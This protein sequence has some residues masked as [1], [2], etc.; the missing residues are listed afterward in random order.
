MRDGGPVMSFVAP[1]TSCLPLKPR[2]RMLPRN[3]LSG[4]VSYRPLCRR[5]PE[6][7]PRNNAMN[8]ATAGGVMCRAAKSSIR[9]SW[10]FAV[11]LL[12][13]EL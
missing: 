7:R 6:T 13:L 3:S 5:I 9:A 12:C 1:T 11:D 2:A 4:V 10:P 8:K